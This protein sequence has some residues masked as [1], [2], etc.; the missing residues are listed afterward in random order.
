MYPVLE[1]FL[2]YIDKEIVDLIVCKDEQIRVLQPRPRARKWQCVM[3]DKIYVFLGLPMLMVQKST[4]K[5]YFSRDAFLE[6]LIF[7]QTMT[8]QI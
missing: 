6:T 8:R 5:S 7:F 2:L 4:L 1:A 3:D